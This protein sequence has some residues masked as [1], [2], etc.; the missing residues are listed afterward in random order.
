MENPSG[1]AAGYNFYNSCYRNDVGRWAGKGHKP[2]ENLP[3]E[4]ELNAAACNSSTI[5][6]CM[7]SMRNGCRPVQT[8]TTLQRD[9]YVPHMPVTG[10]I[11][12][13]YTQR[14][15][16][17]AAPPD[18]PADPSVLRPST[19]YGSRY[20]RAISQPFV[21]QET[22]DRCEMAKV[23]TRSVTG[24]GYQPGWNSSYRHQFCEKA[25]DP[26]YSEAVTFHSNTHL[27]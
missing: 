23:S 11:G 13:T 6:R 21:S 4:I 26:R 2:S 17:A 27:R 22:V 1:T 14:C 18:A 8:P 20:R 9:S 12:P 16:P 24:R 3:R 25:A 15:P 5:T 19:E 7:I 10:D